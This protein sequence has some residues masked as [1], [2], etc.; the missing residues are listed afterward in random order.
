MPNH[1]LRP[2]RRAVLTT[3]TLAAGTAVLVTGCDDD[4]G[5]SGTGRTPPGGKDGTPEPA[6]PSKDPAA[7]AALTTAATQVEQI[8]LRYSAVGQAFP[9]LRTQLASGVKSRAAHLAKLKEIGGSEPPQPG[10]LPALPK[11][12]VAALNDLA[13]REQ[14]LSVAH[15]T[16][17]T[18]VSGEAARLLAMLAA[19][20]SQLALTLGRKKTAT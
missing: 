2:S 8:A 7:V 1:A 3:A 4:P 12:A 16:A 6:P 10:K 15:A 17:A 11:T 19:A 18:K 9:A 13:V 5:D 14:K 20:E